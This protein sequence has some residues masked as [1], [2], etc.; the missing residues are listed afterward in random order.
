MNTTYTSEH[1]STKTLGAVQSYSRVEISYRPTT[2]VLSQT[3]LTSR[4][5]I[6]NLYLSLPYQSANIL[7]VHNRIAALRF[8]LSTKRVKQ[9][10]NPTY[11]VISNESLKAMAEMV[12]L[13]CDGSSHCIQLPYR[14]AVF[15]APPIVSS[16]TCVCAETNEASCE[17]DA[18][19]DVPLSSAASFTS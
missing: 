2:T 1:G 6:S 9:E 13:S 5:A 18:V 16:S 12:I 10:K 7:F 15:S 19:L 14:D 11:K 17:D 4:A 8:L 3:W